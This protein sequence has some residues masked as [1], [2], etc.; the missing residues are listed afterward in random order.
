MSKGKQSHLKRFEARRSHEGRR[1]T[2]TVRTGVRIELVKRKDSNG[3][4]DNAR[5]ND[6]VCLAVKGRHG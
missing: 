1:L 5:R 6:G 3:G 2:K 4:S